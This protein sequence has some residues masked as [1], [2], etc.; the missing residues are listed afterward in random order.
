MTQPPTQQPYQPQGLPQNQS[1]AHQSSAHQSSAH[2]SSA[3]QSS[4]HQSSAQQY[5]PQQQPSAQQ[6]QAQQQYGT[7]WSAGVTSTPEDNR[8]RDAL[9]RVRTEVG[10][11]VVGQDEAV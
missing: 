1:S 7:Q 3:H 2:Q 9:W 8:A 10:K 6:F 5:Q 11:V 4:A